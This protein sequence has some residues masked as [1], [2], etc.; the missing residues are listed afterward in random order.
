VNYFTALFIECHDSFD[1]GLSANH[2]RFAGSFSTQNTD[3]VNLRLFPGAIWQVSLV[4]ALL[5][6][7]VGGWC[8]E[9]FPCWALF[10]ASA[11][12]SRA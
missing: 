6:F 11:M 1:L 5:V 2:I 9:R 8:L 3:P 7:F 10:F 12:R 4:T